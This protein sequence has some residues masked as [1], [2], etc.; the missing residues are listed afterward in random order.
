MVQR[1]AFGRFREDRRFAAPVEGS[2]RD[3]L[4]ARGSTFAEFCVVDGEAK[5]Y[6]AYCAMRGGCG[7]TPGAGLTF[8][9]VSLHRSVI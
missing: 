5:Y 1:V 9:F 3:G 6:D 2:F 4:D 8:C 7:A